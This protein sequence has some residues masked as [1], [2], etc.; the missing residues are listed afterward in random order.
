MNVQKELG[1]MR[2][3]QLI[4]FVNTDSTKNDSNKDTNSLIAST[5][6]SQHKKK[7]DNRFI[8]SLEAQRTFENLKQPKTEEKKQRD[9]F[10]Y[11]IRTVINM[12]IFVWST[13]SWPL[14]VH[15]IKTV[16]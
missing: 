1:L 9:E 2:V 15:S 7:R 16:C 14:G 4:F 6:M 3:H 13:R 8:S 5:I 12:D 11:Q 10:L